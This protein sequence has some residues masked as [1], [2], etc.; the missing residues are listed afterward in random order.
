LDNRDRRCYLALFLLFFYFAVEKFLISALP[1]WLIYYSYIRPLFMIAVIIGLYGLKKTKRHSSL[2]QQPNALIYAMIL[3]VLYFL[4]FLLLGIIEGFGN[5][6]FDTSLKG[7]LLNLFNM[8][9]YLVMIEMIRDQLINKMDHKKFNIMAIWIV[10]VFTFTEVN[11]NTALSLKW[12]DIEGITKFIGTSIL[13]NVMKNYYLCIVAAMAGPVGGIITQLSYR[14]AYYFFPVLPNLKWITEAL[15]NT[16][17]PLF[18]AMSLKNG[19]LIREGRDRRKRSQEENVWT[20]ALTSF[21]SIGMVWF[22]VGVFPIFPTVVLTG[23]MEPVYFP[24]DVAVVKKIDVKHVREGDIIQYWAESYFIIHRVIDVTE[25][26]FFITKGDNNNATD[27]KPVDPGMVKGKIIARVPLIGKPV[28]MVRS[29]K[30]STVEDV[31]EKF[32]LGRDQK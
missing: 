26:G 18:C 31:K 6:P 28:V 10:L 32:E 21:L 1:I 23:S 7:I 4:T 9:P 14:V 11:W 15:L 25:D 20:W 29:L 17:F 8:M 30:S 3:G 19:I 27:L 24:G 12:T 2:K 16:M 22:S 13:P 5:N